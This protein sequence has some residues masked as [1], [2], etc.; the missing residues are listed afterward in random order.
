MVQDGWKGGIET[1]SR[2][3]IKNKKLR[4]PIL[5]SK[6]KAE[7]G[8]W[9]RPLFPKYAPNDILHPERLYC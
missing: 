4:A 9:K 8:N 1:S 5:Y 6:H 3:E 2:F 7:R